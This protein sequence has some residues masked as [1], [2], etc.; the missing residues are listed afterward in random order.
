MGHFNLMH[1]PNLYAVEVTLRRNASGGVVSRERP[2]DGVTVWEV[3]HAEIFVCSG[4][5]QKKGRRR[6]QP[7]T[8]SYNGHVFVNRTSLRR[9]GNQCLIASPYNGWS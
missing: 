2:T 3:R 8:L 9:R 5:E 7:P 1:S 6:L 4:A